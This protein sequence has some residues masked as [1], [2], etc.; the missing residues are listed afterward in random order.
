M[1]VILSVVYRVKDKWMGRKRRNPE[2]R[3]KT[4]LKHDRQRAGGERGKTFAYIMDQGRGGGWRRS[5]GQ[6]VS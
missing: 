6:M 4:L 2:R 5:L 1:P 3:G